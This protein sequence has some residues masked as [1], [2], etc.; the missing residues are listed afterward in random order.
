MDM[1]DSCAKMPS[2]EPWRKKCVYTTLCGETVHLQPVLQPQSLLITPWEGEKCPCPAQCKKWTTA[3]RWGFTPPKGENQKVSKW[4]T[5]CHIYGPSVV[6][7]NKRESCIQIAVRLGVPPFLVKTT[8]HFYKVTGKFVF[9]RVISPLPSEGSGM[10]SGTPV[11]IFHVLQMFAWVLSQFSCV[12]L[13]VTPW[14]VAHQAPLS[15]GFTR[16]EYGSGLPCPTPRIFPTQ[17]SNLCLLS[18]AL[19]GGVF[20]MEPY[21]RPLPNPVVSNAELLVLDLSEALAT[22]DCPGFH[23]SLHPLGQSFSVPFAASLA[24]LQ[25]VNVIML[26][27]L[28]LLVI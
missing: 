26:Q 6:C 22:A 24:S 16:Q 9:H 1:G 10:Y 11:A 8:G 15:M 14:T 13:F 27:D 28:S 3:Q 23:V 17:R 4:L 25:P 2:W 7:H 5:T 19:A 18:P 12:W 20:A 21:V